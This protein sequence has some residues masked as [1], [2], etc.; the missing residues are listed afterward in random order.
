M[1]ESWACTSASGATFLAMN[2]VIKAEFFFD[3]KGLVF[4]FFVFVANDIVRTGHNASGTPCAETRV[5]DFFV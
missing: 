5:D 4:T 1:S 3:M 2:A